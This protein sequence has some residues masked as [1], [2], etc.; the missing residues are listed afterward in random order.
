MSSARN[1]VSGPNLLT[2]GA[3]LEQT[4]GVSTSR[5]ADPLFRKWLCSQRAHCNSR[6]HLLATHSVLAVVAHGVR[7]GLGLLTVP[8]TLN[9]LGKERYG[10]WM[11]ALSTLAF[12]GLFD[13]GLSPALK[14]K[15]AEAFAIE[16]EDAFHYYSSGGWVL[17]C[18]VAILGLFLLPFLAL[19]DW[20][21]VYG[22]TGQVTRREAQDL[23]LACFGMSV[24]TVALSFVDALFA[25]RM[26][27]G[28]VYL[29]NAGASVVGFAVLLTAVHFQAGIVVLAITTSAPQIAAR[30]A[31]LVSARRRGII[32]FSAPSRSVRSLLRS[33]VPTS[34]SF[35]G[36]Q[37]AC[38]VITAVP[39]LIA[40]RLSGL[41][42]VTTLVVGQR[43]ASV[44]LMVVAAVAPVFWPAFTIAWA[45]GD[46]EWM[47]KQCVRLVG[48]TVTALA[49]YACALV[50]L[51]PLALRLWLRGS[52]SV[53]RSVLAVFGIWLV[54]QGVSHWVSTLLHSVTDLRTQVICYAAQGLLLAIL[55]TILCTAY[56]V[57][58]ITI[59]MTVALAL[60]NI[61]PLG[62][63]T[64]STLSR[65]RRASVCPKPHP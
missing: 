65:R 58:G 27:L 56:G 10:L 1:A 62:W 20:S 52:V 53:P 23:T 18:L 51:G 5:E 55:G 8:I 17:V 6:A 28:T 64:Y 25:S 40:S 44:P 21:A 11:L 37:I 43:I 54:F 47:R 33:I 24:V 61:A 42:S 14:N 15:M 9:Y 50:L 36:I 22:I 2:G 38:F 35:L 31:L 57:L 63:R 60:A 48:A 19:V 3:S 46:L 4:N 30:L 7:M 49:L 32:R 45:K 39:N 13:A 34:A 26:L 16:D 12:V 59:S 41:S 29:Y